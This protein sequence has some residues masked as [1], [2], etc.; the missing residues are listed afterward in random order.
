MPSR[1]THDGR[2]W[3][4]ATDVIEESTVKHLAVLIVLF[5]ITNL[6]SAAH[7]QPAPSPE[8]DDFRKAQDAL[9]AKYGVKANS[10]YLNLKKPQTTV[11]VLEA[12]QG[13]PLVLIHGGR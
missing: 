4:Q 11:H 12:G 1:R 6:S 9:L 10:R 8:V 3:L 5:L 7:A 2:A 13:K